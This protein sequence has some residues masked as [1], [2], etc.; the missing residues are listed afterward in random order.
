MPDGLIVTIRL[1]FV[2]VLRKR[3]SFSCGQAAAVFGSSIREEF[4][5]VFEFAAG[6]LR[7]L[8]AIGDI[9]PDAA[10]SN[11]ADAA[12]ADFGSILAAA[13]AVDVF[14][15]EGVVIASGPFLG[16]PCTQVGIVVLQSDKRRANL[17]VQSAAGEFH[18]LSLRSIRFCLLKR[19][20]KIIRPEGEK[21]NFF[22]SP[23]RG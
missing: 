12:M 22:V 8:S 4:E 23:L 15:P 21:Y 18:G 6:E 9:L 20:A 11:L 14:G 2:K 17:A 3:G 19:N 7:A 10:G 1:R 16:R 13:G 5:E